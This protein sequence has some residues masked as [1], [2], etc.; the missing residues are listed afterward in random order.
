VW[1]MSC[2]VSILARRGAESKQKIK[3]MRKRAKKVAKKGEKGAILPKTTKKKA[4]KGP[5]N[6]KSLHYCTL[7]SKI[8]LLTGRKVNNKTIKKQ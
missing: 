8:T 1:G 5:K 7:C 6:K 2:D 3:I 4:K